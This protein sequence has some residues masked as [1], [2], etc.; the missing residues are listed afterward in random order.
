MKAES[1][2]NKPSTRGKAG[3]A[4]KSATRNQAGVTSRQQA[5]AQAALKD[6]LLDI[7]K[8]LSLPG[9][10]Q[11]ITERAVRLLNA[12]GGGMYLNEPDQR[13]VR[14]VAEYKTSRSLLSTVIAYGDGA[15]GRVAETGEPLMIEDYGT[16]S[17]RA[18]GFD[19]KRPSG[20]VICA[21]M[22]WQGQITGV[23]TV[24]RKKKFTRNE[25]DLL[26][27]FADHAAVAVENA[28]LRASLMQDQ[29]S[30][31]EANAKY[32]DL[33]ERLPFVV[34]TAEVGANG[35]WQ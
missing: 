5:E 3:A 18:A 27:L 17:G 28:R 15:S 25:L 20:A 34:Y 14:C 11:S 29:K 22:K 31:R 24:L 13:R 33:V 23:F 30:A 12:S 1:K 10:L 9:L 19:E 35:V 7:T 4:Q 8:G 2:S 26:T 6:T 21:P 16:W 32:R